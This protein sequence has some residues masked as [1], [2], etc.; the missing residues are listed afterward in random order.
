LILDQVELKEEETCMLEFRWMLEW[1]LQLSKRYARVE[2]EASD[3]SA[4]EYREV[5]LLVAG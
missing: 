2:M 3:R 4:L 1:S 5:C